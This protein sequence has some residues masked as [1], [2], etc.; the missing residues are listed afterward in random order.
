M[1]WYMKNI[2]NNE[3]IKSQ[4][5]VPFYVL[6]MRKGSYVASLCM[7]YFLVLLVKS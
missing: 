7:T 1:R 6:Y 4:A 5:F 3:K 2:F